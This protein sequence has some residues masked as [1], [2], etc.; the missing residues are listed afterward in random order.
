MKD[1]NKIMYIL[2]RKLANNY[3]E[4]PE[5]SLSALSQFWYIFWLPELTLSF[6]PL[7][8]LFLLFS[9]AGSAAG[10]VKLRS[11]SDKKKRCDIF[12]HAEI[13]INSLLYYEITDNHLTNRHEKRI[14]KC[15]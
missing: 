1:S 11:F 6:S 3:I 15:G 7:W 10:P 9:P 14:V 12:K 5:V 4:P 8:F 13:M 2:F